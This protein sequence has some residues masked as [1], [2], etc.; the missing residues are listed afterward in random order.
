MA[1]LCVDVG[2]LGSHFESLTD[3]RHT[4]N[5]KHLLVDIVVISL[6]GILCGESGT[7]AIHR[8]AKSKREWL[9]KPLALPHGI[10]SHDGLRRLLL[11]LKPE[12][13][14][15]CFEEWIASGVE[16]DATGQQLRSLR[17]ETPTHPP[18]SSPTNPSLDKIFLRTCCSLL[19]GIELINATRLET[20]ISA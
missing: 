9:S 17:H 6:C 3:P 18:P 13:F 20:S 7:T 10:P 14:Q 2:S 12:A 15:K 19:S 1:E 8:W 11:I 5:R 16:V 4:R